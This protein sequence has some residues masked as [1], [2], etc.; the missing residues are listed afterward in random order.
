MSPNACADLH[1]RLSPVATKHLDDLAAR[2][3]LSRQNA[4]RMLL[5]EAAIQKLFGLPAPR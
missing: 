5:S 3:G 1:L 4:I 2:H